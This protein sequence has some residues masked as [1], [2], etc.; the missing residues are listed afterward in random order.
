MKKRPASLVEAGQKETP[1][2]VPAIGGAVRGGRH[3][4]LESSPS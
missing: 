2:I 3:F 4:I 1:Y